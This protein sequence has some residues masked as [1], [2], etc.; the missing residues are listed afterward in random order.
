MSRGDV[1]G[2]S[3]GESPRRVR[4]PGAW[5]R[6]E[7]VQL[8]HAG[9]RSVARR[10]PGAARGTGPWLSQARHLAGECMLATQMC[11]VNL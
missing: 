11:E 3:D 10:P 5:R 7:R 1:G 4:R 6:A 2:T 8:V 9:G